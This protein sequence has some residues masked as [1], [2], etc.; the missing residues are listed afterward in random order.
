MDLY[1]IRHADAVKWDEP[2][3]HEDAER[4][5]TEAGETQARTLATALQR[6]GVRLSYVL[7]S[8]LLRAR[9]TAE[10]MLRQ[11]TGASPELRTCDALAPGGRRKRLAKAVD[12]LDAEAV[13]VVGHDPDLSE[14]V[15]WLLGS[16]KIAVELAKAGVALL[17]CPDGVGKGQGSLAWLVTPEWLGEPAGVGNGRA[18]KT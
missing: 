5:L 13:A 16:R 12:K 6:R 4:P 2:D 11:W 3:G 7:C 9:Q 17:H 14:F 15:G 10:G 1:V 18:A 8:P